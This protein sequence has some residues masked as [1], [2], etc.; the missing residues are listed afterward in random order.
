[1]TGRS[2]LYVDS[3]KLDEHPGHDS[4]S[5]RDDSVSAGHNNGALVIKMRIL[6]ATT[7]GNQFHHSI[8]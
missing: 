1:M 3:N 8:V 4:D 2:S 5:I 7:A 6:S